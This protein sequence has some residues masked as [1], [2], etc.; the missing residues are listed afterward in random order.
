MPSQDMNADSI[1]NSV[2]AQGARLEQA[3]EHL[4]LSKDEMSALLGTSRRTYDR[5]AAGTQE[6]RGDHLA[7]LDEKG[8]DPTWLVTGRGSLFGAVANF[9]ATGSGYVLV[10]R[11]DIEA[12]AGHGALIAEENV[13]DHMA[14]RED[15]IR[16]AL[17][18]D[19]RRL[20][21]ITA[22]GDSMEPVIRSGDL[23]LV[24]MSVQRII[25]DT[26]YIVEVSGNLLV[27]RIQQFL[28]GVIVKSENPS[29]E[30]WTLR[31]DEVA[32]LQVR[33]RIR[34]IGRLI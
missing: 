5:Y 6:C 18:V 19:P 12:S 11:Y 22:A 25:D 20:A 14:F 34:W 2:K 7:K 31:G 24:D 1:G 28:G 29:Y 13:L 10:P 8:V 27:K 17:R 16:R 15:W 9:G 3:R 26:I 21:L 4:G 32:D 23:L 33:G 30:P